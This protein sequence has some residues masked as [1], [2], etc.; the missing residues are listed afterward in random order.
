M[1]LTKEEKKTFNLIIDRFNKDG[2]PSLSFA[3]A[4]NTCPRN[5]AKRLERIFTISCEAR[6]GEELEG[7]LSLVQFVDEV[8]AVARDY[9][10]NNH[11]FYSPASILDCCF[12]V[13]SD[14]SKPLIRSLDFFVTSRGDDYV[15]KTPGAVWEK[16]PGYD[17]NI[18]CEDMRTWRTKTPTGWVMTN[19]EGSLLFVPDPKHEWL[20]EL[21]KEVKDG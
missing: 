20:P 1:F 5:K 17:G 14:L 2:V 4:I 6:K 15:E 8:T 9:E 11:G 12:G 7:S 13:R 19:E 21:T 16:V 18:L 10:K 3:E